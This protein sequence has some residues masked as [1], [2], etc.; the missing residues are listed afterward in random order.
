MRQYVT[1]FATANAIRMKR[2]VHT[3]AF[4]VLEG[5]SDALLFQ[6]LIDQEACRIEVAYGKSN[7]TDVI[8][9]L[10]TDNFHGALG[11]IDAD[12][13]RL[14]LGGP[15]ETMPNLLVTDDHDIECMYLR[16]VACDRVVS[17]Y[18]V[19]DK[20]EAFCSR[21]G[22]VIS[23]LL[24]DKAVPLGCLRLIS[25]RDKLNLNFEELTFSRFVDL[26]SLTIDIRAMIKTVMDKS[27]RHDLDIDVLAS[28]VKKVATIGHDRWQ[29]ACGHDIVELLA[30]GFRKALCSLKGTE[31]A[32][33][34]IERSLRL[35][36]DIADFAS[37][38]LFASIKQWEAANPGFRV[39]GLA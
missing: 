24:A 34:L 4:L 33:D 28:E 18:A 1:A 29:I 38:A 3:G 12:Y 35:A 16:T 37:T 27:S 36:Y 2:T 31:I 15:H 10:N 19:P 32:A 6:L 8:R 5:W 9:I 25:L 13:E 39:L 26:T 20:V 11:I 23:S 22:S 7:V 30:L 21:H 14:L 17:E